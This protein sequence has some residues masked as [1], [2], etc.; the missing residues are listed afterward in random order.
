MFF[1]L[2]KV[3]WTILRPGNL[4]VLMLL[5]GCA[6]HL[7]PWARVRA[8]GSCL[9]AFTALAML[10]I[11]VLPLGDWL[12]APLEDRFPPL[13]DPP[14]VVD[15][16]ILLGGA[17]ELRIAA[18][19]GKAELNHAA[20]RVMAFTGLARRYPK[21]KLIFSGGSGSLRD[22]A[23]RE[24]DFVKPLLAE[25]GRDPDRLLLQ[26][27]S[28]NTREDAVYSKALARP[29]PGEVWLLVTSASHM[30][31]AVGVF[32]RVG[33]EVVPVPVDFQTAGSGAW[34]LNFDFEKGLG[35]VTRGLR[36]W[37]GLLAYWLWDWTDCL[38][39]NRRG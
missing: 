18:N 9:L 34:R 4:L 20:D 33:W 1:V 25:L 27:A 32:R 22:Q 16:I 28:R 5:A 36:E 8:A 11:A 21:A 24:A 19:R 23:Y 10:A 14:P 37:I 30:P 15:G 12:L 17:I 31:R 3:F 13:G 29:R 2:S 38:F 39:P 35:L 7:A 26:G 6:A